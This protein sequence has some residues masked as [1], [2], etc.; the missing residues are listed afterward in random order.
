MELINRILNS[1]VVWGAWILIPFIMEVVPAVGSFL[2]LIRR[3]TRKLVKPNTN[4]YPEISIIVPVYNSEDTLFNC[5]KSIA[6][7]NYPSSKIHVFLVN[8]QGKDN[9]FSVF[10]KCQEKF[11]ELHQ[12]WLNSKQGKSRAL[13]LAL[14]NSNGK[15]IINIDSDG[16]LEPNALKNLVDRFEARQDI[17]CMTGYFRNYSENLSIWNM[18]KLFWLEEAMHLKPILF[19]HCQAHFLHLENL[20]Y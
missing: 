5:I 1:F 7:S 14:Y 2:L 17:N 12:Q 13:N 8:N 16:V 18:L 15:Y 11:P 9:S 6:E 20:Q 3:W 19:I 10:A 4:Y